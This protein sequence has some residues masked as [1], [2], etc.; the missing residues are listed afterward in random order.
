MSMD[1]NLWAVVCS[2][3]PMTARRVW[4]A[5]FYKNI[6]TR[7]QTVSMWDHQKRV[8]F[9]PERRGQFWNSNRQILLVTPLSQSTEYFFH[10]WFD[11]VPLLSV[12]LTVNGRSLCLSVF[13]LSRQPFLQ[14]TS[15]LASVLLRTQGSAASS[16]KLLDERFFRKL[17]MAIARA[18]Q[19]AHS[20]RARFE[21]HC[22]VIDNWWKKKVFTVNHWLYV[23]GETFLSCP[24]RPEWISR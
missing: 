14:S 12:H 15:L 6:V 11:I 2:L 7:C 21:W 1:I 24:V 9:E 17:R 10:P 16:V 18:T 22:T 19:S 13:Q 4:G 5:G 3:Q 23:W 20:K 8:R